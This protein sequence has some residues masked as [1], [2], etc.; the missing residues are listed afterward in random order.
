MARGIFTSTADL[1]RKFMQ[2]IY[3][4]AA[5]SATRTRLSPSAVRARDVHANAP[6]DAHR[7]HPTHRDD[8]SPNGE[9]STR[10]DRRVR[11]K[12][13]SAMSLAC[14]FVDEAWPVVRDACPSAKLCLRRR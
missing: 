9:D 12:P 2:Y 7:L 5:C 6:L 1:R 10:T 4:P 14:A 3:R 8:R 11:R 13:D